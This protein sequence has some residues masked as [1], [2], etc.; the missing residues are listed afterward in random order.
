MTSET[1]ERAIGE[2]QI[3]ILANGTPRSIQFEDTYYDARDGLGESRHVFLKGCDLPKAWAGHDTYT[4]GETGFGTG[5]NFLSAWQAWLTSHNRPTRLNYVSVEGFPLDAGKLNDVL[6]PW[7]ELDPIAK[8][9]IESY[10]IPQPGYH[11][12]FFENGQISLT[13]L[14]GQA[15]PILTTLDA[16]VDAWFLDGFAPDRNPDMWHPDLFQEI[17]R[18]STPDAKLATFT[19]AGQVRRDL[20]K[21]GFNLQKRSGLGN[22]RHVLAG[23]YSASPIHPP[24]EPPTEPWYRLKKPPIAQHKTAVVIGSGLAG[25]FTAHALK[26]RGCAVTV[27]ERNPNVAEETSA[28]PAA[29][30]M[31]RLTAGASLDGG[32]YAHAWSH[33][34]YELQDL[35]T[36]G[37]DFGLHQCGALL[38]ALTPDEKRRQ[39]TISASGVLPKQFLQML[40]AGDASARA[41]HSLEQGGLYFPDAGFLSAPRLCEALLDSVSVLFNQRADRLDC[42]GAQWIVNDNNNTKIANADFVVIAGGLDSAAF[43]QTAWLPL[44]ARRGQITQVPSTPTSQTLK[45]VIGGEGYIT[46]A[47]DGLHAMGATFDHVREGEHAAALK[48][49]SKSDQR[50]LELVNTVVPGLFE[51]VISSGESWVGLRCT[52]NDH[53]P[54]I[55][56]LPDHDSYIQDFSE[57][58]HGHRWSEYPDARYHNGLYVMTG[59]GAHGTVIAPLA[60]EVIASQIFGDPSLLPRSLSQAL[61]PGRFIARDLKRGRA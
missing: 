33:L 43:E 60:A 16:R 13:L 9:L 17:A 55:G 40:S 20:E 12:R 59:L 47:R 10:P 58:R 37:H 45:C 56:P 61:H 48:P 52:T 54:I 1:P 18:L 30:F 49:D 44:T 21:A 29:V 27:I 46:P 28:T 57:L 39:T 8:Q 11:R 36:K 3:E 38:P 4:I 41:G 7:P 19:V 42:E 2:A 15:L 6:R 26:R 32:V 24:P 14:F 5:L 25:A 51:R 34:L 22:K 35:V 50:N 23:R 31:P 53:L